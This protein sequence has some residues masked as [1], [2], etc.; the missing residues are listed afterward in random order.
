V[1]LKLREI[2]K[3]ERLGFDEEMKDTANTS[4]Y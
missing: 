2:L 4:N 1:I 3:G